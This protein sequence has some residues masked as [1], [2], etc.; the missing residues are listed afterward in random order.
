MTE[1]HYPT[2]INVR[3]AQ[4]TWVGTGGLR[5]CFTECIASKYFLGKIMGNGLPSYIDIELLLDTLT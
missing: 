2:F 5:G 4:L 3:I 1:G